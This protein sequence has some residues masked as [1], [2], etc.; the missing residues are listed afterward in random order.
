MRHSII[1]VETVQEGDLITVSKP[2]K[3]T[4]QTLTGTIVRIL[5][6]GKVR[7]LFTGE[8]VEMA[9]YAIG[10]KSGVTV[11]LV[12]RV[13]PAHTVLSVFEDATEISV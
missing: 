12:K 6:E 4:V 13:D 11:T 10:R 2:Y 5:A 3:D 8:G 1:P 7:T 9:R